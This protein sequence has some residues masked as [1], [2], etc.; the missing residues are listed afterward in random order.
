MKKALITVA[1]PSFN[2]GEY[3]DDTLTSIFEQNVPVEVF[4][5]DGGSTDTSLDVIRKWEPKLTGWRSRKDNAQAAAINEGIELG[6]AP[7][8]C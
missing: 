6:T 5:M 7:Y 3:L 1:V 8:V 2:Q 4:V